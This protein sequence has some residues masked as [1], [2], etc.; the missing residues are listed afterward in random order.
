MTLVPTST[1]SGQITSPRASISI[2]DAVRLW[3]AQYSSR[4]TRNAYAGEVQAFGAFAGRAPLDAVAWLLALDAAQAHTIIDAYR[5]SMISA[6]KSPST[7]N[8]SLSAISSL[9]RSARRHGLTDLVLDYKGVKSE[10]YRD[11]KGPGTRGVNAMI[12]AA[13]SNRIPWRVARDEAIVRLL[14][15]LGLRRAELCSLDVAHLD[16]EAGAVSVMGKGRT[17]RRTLTVPPSAQ[18]ALKAW[19]GQRGSSPGPLF[20]GQ[21]SRERLTENGLYAVVKALARDAGVTARPHGIRHAA[22]TAVLDATNGDLRKAQAFGRHA[23]ATTTL[24]YD[25]NR[26]DQAGA[27][28]ALVDALME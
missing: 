2:D 17:E 4:N 19:L 16:A 15:A 23:S 5:A 13:R 21:D 14:F 10:S 18:R 26:Q 12:K 25:D 20:L 24:V 22:I 1:P 28:A 8:R 9:V 6:G 27:A 11:T 3:L 7:I